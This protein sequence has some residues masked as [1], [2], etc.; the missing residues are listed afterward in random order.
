MG[1]ISWVS[2]AS[3]S[4]FEFDGEFHLVRAN[5]TEHLGQMKT[6]LPRGV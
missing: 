2:N 4:F 1:R 6:D 5:C 3:V